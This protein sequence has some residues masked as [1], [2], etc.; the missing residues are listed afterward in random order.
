MDK[1]EYHRYLAS[2]EWAILKEEVRN[3]SGGRCERCL[4]FPYR[5][6]HHLTYERIGKEK[7]ADL[8]AV[9]GPCH[10]YLSGK[11]DDDPAAN[12]LWHLAWMLMGNPK[13]KRNKR[14]EFKCREFI[15]QILDGVK[16]IIYKNAMQFAKHRKERK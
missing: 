8:I 11:R 15:G 12:L 16:P 9:C 7:P 10:E 1:S 6:I 14:R 3:R 5:D 2:R 4:E 13:P